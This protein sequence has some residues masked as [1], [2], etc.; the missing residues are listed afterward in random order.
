[1]KVLVTGGAG[2]IGSHTVVE[3]AAAGMEPVIVDNFS[4]SRPEVLARIEQIVGRPVEF[5]ECDVA[6]AGA[7]DKVFARVRPEAVIHFAGFK[8]VG[9]SMEQPL[10]YYRNNL[11]STIALAEVMARHDVKRIVFS[12]TATVYGVPRTNPIREDFPCAPAN[13]YGRTKLMSEQI[14][15]DAADADPELGV[16]LLRYFNPVGAHESALIGE[17]PADIPNNLMPFVS[18]VAVG[19]HEFVRV[20][21]NDYD[22]PD[23]TGVRDYLHVVDLAR[24]HVKALEHGAG[25]SG[26]AVY[27]LGSGK[28]HSV[29]EVIRAYEKAAGKTLPYR[30]L[31]RR[32]GDIDIYYA[33]PALAE[34]E[35]GWRAEKSLDDMCADAWRWQS[36]NPHGYAKS[37]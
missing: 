20:F 24:A 17:D 26:V 5:H 12:S 25:R 27:N 13:V 28:P 36:R 1:M 33:D 6:D 31:V 11:L 14:L 9:E 2:Y 18:Q 10:K 30:V 8:A 4:N 32:P 3:L 34:K 15:Q 29:M 23:G 37:R 21:G 16:T 19:K 22:T 35:L 7:L